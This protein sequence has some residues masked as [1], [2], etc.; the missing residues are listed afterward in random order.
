MECMG[1]IAFDATFGKILEIALAAGS[2]P[3]DSYDSATGECI[4]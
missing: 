4:S 3:L 1:Q 2:M